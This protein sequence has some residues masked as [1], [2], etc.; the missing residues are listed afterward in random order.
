MHEAK[1]VVESLAGTAEELLGHVEMLRTVLDGDD[2]AEETRAMTAA[3]P[4]AKIAEDRVQI[5]REAMCKSIN[6][7]CDLRERLIRLVNDIG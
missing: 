2:F 5:A 4:R 1:A 7:L 3:T 6:I